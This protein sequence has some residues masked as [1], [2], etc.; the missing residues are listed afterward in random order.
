MIWRKVIVGN[1]DLPIGRLIGVL[2]NADWVNQGRKHLREDGICPFCQRRTITDELKNQLEDFFSG[3][4][5]QDV[6]HIKHCINQYGACANELLRRINAL[7]TSLGTYPAAGI[8]VSKLDTIIELL[9]GYFSKNKAEML[10]KEKE[11]GRTISL[12]ETVATIRLVE[13]LVVDGNDTI[14]KHN[15][16]VENYTSEKNVLVADICLSRPVP[17]T[18]V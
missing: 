1:K 15:S 4:Y 5:E 8:D 13:Q 14:A 11:P 10:I 7:R 6:N 16:M 3:E 18:D 9:N 17:V 2:D 12:T